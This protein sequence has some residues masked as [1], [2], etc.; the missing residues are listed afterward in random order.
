M[1]EVPGVLRLQFLQFPPQPQVTMNSKNDTTC[2]DRRPCMAEGPWGR[3]QHAARSMRWKHRLLAQR[4]TTR[5]CD[6]QVWKLGCFD[7]SVGGQTVL[8]QDFSNLAHVLSGL[9]VVQLF[10]SSMQEPAAFAYRTRSL[11]FSMNP[12]EA[13]SAPFVRASSRIVHSTR[14][15]RIHTKTLSIT[16]SPRQTRPSHV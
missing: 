2:I 12:R 3:K 5:K 10:R 15:T 13:A 1:G 9:S 6:L 14:D 16:K 8:F 4:S 11:H 7:R